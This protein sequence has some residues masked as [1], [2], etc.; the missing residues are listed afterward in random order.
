M[1]NINLVVCSLEKIEYFCYV[2]LSVARKY[3]FRELQCPLDIVV[4]RDLLHDMSQTLSDANSG[5]TAAQEACYGFGKP[6]LKEM[7]VLPV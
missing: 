3:S 6:I 2:P 1:T 5:V 7:M 4:F